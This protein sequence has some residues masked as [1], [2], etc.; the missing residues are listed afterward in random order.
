MNEHFYL[1]NILL[2]LE[3]T[4]K[5]LKGLGQPSL[6]LSVLAIKQRVEIL[7]KQQAHRDLSNVG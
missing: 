3:S 2:K 1:A 5:E 7:Q 6:A 4:A